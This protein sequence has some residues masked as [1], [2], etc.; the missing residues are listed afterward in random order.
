V[1]YCVYKVVSLVYGELT[2]PLRDLPGP[3][4]K[5]IIFGN[6]KELFSGVSCQYNIS[7]WG[8]ASLSAH[9]RP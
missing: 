9:L 6:F 8:R 5:S 4:N 7:C 1:L 2:S 3:P